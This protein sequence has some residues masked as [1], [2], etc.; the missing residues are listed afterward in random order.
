MSESKRS[1]LEPAEPCCQ[2]VR[3]GTLVRKDG[4]G[5]FWACCVADGEGRVQSENT[6]KMTRVK[7]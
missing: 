7:V 2:L 3:W 1:G 6:E 4:T 5:H